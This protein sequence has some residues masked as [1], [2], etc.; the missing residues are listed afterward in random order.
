MRGGVSIG[1][2]SLISLSLSPGARRAQGHA[3]PFFFLTSLAKG[4]LR[5]SSSVDRWYLRISR[6]A[7]VPGRYRRLPAAAARPVKR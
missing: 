1:S 3:F 5:M 4:S 6:R 7:T 2:S